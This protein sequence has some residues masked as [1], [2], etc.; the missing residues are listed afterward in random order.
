MTGAHVPLLGSDLYEVAFLAGGPR[1][2]VDAAVVAL[3]EAGRLLVFRSIAEVH[4]VDPQPRHP[5]EAAVLD[6]AEPRARRSLDG[7]VRRVR[8]DARLVALA[9]GLRQAGLVSRRGGVDATGEWPWT[10]VGPTRAGRRALRR[11]RSDSTLVGRSEAH[12]VALGGPRTW[13]DGELLRAVVFAPPRP[14][15][16]ADPESSER[17]ARRSRSA[18]WAHGVGEGWAG[19]DW[20]GLGG[21]SGGDCGA[22]GGSAGGG[23]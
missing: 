4:V 2:V 8:T 16:P 10:A 21:G 13:A 14:H 6:A 17:E 20:G 1:R 15:P 5:V 18:A 9:D 12:A 19:A 3:V 22:G 11:L 7:V 23:C